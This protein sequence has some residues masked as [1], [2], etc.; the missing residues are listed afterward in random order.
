MLFSKACTYAIRAAI[1]AASKYP[2]GRR[3]FIPIRELAEEVDVSFH[4]LTKILQKLTEANIMES[5]RGP[6][7]GVGLIRPANQVSVIEIIAA[8]DGLNLFQGCALGLPQCNDESPCPL[9]DAWSKRREDLQKML[10]RTTLND[11]VRNQ[12]RKTSR[13]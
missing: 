6:N 8:I 1:L 9:H 10:T 12:T 5:F 11:L 7:G 2:E 4:F 3:N 13:G